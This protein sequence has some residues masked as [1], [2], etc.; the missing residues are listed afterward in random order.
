M[1]WRPAAGPATWRKR[2]GL[3]ATIRR[4]FADR[5]VF[6][7]ETPLLARYSVTDTA[8]EAFPVPDPRHPG[9]SRYLQTS[10]EYAMK[11]L[12]AAHGESVFQICKAFREGDEESWARRLLQARMEQGRRLTAIQALRL[13]RRR[14]FD[15]ETI[16]RM[17]TGLDLNHGESEI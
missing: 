14:G 3:L 7:V 13:L 2:A 8:I 9:R 1:E 10:P 16:E 6:E 12:L 5:S 11:R 4:F 15:E 17:M